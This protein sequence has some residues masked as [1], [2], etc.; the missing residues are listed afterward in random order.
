MRSSTRRTVVVAALSLPTSSSS[1]RAPG[2][3]EAASGLRRCF[4]DAVNPDECFAALPGIDRRLFRGRTTFRP[5]R[6]RSAGLCRRCIILPSG[7]HVPGGNGQ[8][9]RSPRE[10][11]PFA[12]AVQDRRIRRGRPC[13]RAAPTPPPRR[14]RPP[15]K[16]LARSRG[17]RVRVG[18]AFQTRRPRKT[19]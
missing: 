13:D 19:C 10:C 7:G 1:H 16:T 3:R 2:C 9:V 15:I 6:I 14:G 4:A 12:K 5:R 17:E 18:C 8:V 11:R